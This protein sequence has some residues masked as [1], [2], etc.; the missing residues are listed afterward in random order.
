MFWVQELYVSVCIA[1]LLKSNIL[2]NFSIFFGNCTYSRPIYTLSQPSSSQPVSQR[3]GGGGGKEKDFLTRSNLPH[4]NV[5]RH[6]EFVAKTKAIVKK[7][8]HQ[9]NEMRH[10]HTTHARSH[11]LHVQLFGFCGTQQ[12]PNVIYLT[13]DISIV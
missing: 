12:E 7:T 8:Y 4:D 3:M 10:I 9:T 5:I 6:I 11:S 1:I 13:N 2:N